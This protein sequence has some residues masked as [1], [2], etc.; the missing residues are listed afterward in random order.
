[1]D[2]SGPDTSGSS[3]LLLE[4]C[5]VYSFGVG[6]DLS[7]EEAMVKYGESV[8]CNVTNVFVM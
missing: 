2:S 6:N 8:F 7:F 3:G 5:L 1:M 4:P